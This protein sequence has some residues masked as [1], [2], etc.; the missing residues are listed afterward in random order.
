MSY[1]I[2]YKSDTGTYDA[3]SIQALKRDGVQFIR[4]TWV[5]VRIVFIN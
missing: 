4:V 3:P 1:G 5:D 2:T